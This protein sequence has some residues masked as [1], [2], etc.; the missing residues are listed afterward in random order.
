VPTALKG[1]KRLGRYLEEAG[2][3]TSAQIEVALNDQKATGMRFG[4]VLAAR[5]WVKQQTI[6]YFMKKLVIPE[7]QSR[8]RQLQSS[9]SQP[10]SS[11]TSQ[12]GRPSA[13]SIRDSSPASAEA[14]PPRQPQPQKSEVS[15]RR[16]APISKPLPSVP[17][18]DG[19]V[20][21]VG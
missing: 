10:Q 3:V 13:G 17:S 21:W 7:R 6:E 19:D 20:N 18:S 1:R 9:S 15:H 2:L 14:P 11:S 16:E 12:P 5:G 8:E 4:E